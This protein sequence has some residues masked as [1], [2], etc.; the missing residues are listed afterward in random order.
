MLIKPY[1][2][3]QPIHVEDESNS[4]HDDGYIIQFDQK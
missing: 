3:S 2:K 1:Q 4:F